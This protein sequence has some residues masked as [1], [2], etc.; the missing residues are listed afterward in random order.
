ME[1]QNPVYIRLEY[2]NT[3]KCQKD[4]LSSEVFFLNLIT[5]RKKLSLLKMQ[6]VIIKTKISR[7]LKKMKNSAQKMGDSFPKISIPKRKHMETEQI[8][9]TF[10]E[11]KTDDSLDM[12]LR[13]IQEKLKALGSI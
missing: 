1:K 9:E 12:Q 8:S 5:L 11:K 10:S 2:A 6:E 3:L 4:L 13:E 7:E